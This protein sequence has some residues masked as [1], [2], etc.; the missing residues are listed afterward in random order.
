MT[1]EERRAIESLDKCDFTEIHRHFVTKAAARKALPK[2]ERQVSRCG[3][4][5]RSLWT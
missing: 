3:P 4:R 5:G 1:A 2:E